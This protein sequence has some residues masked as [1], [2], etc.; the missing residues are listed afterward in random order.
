MHAYQLRMMLLMG[1][2]NNLT[3]YPI[4][5]IMAKPMAQLVAIFLNS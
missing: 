2:N 4:P 5:P 3:M 1:M